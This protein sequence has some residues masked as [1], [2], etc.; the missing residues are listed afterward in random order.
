M[1]LP[2]ALSRTDWTVAGKNISDTDLRYRHWRERLAQ[3][4]VRERCAYR[5]R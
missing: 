2:A 1:F 3:F 4:G 5:C